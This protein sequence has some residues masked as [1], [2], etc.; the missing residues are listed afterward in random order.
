MLLA[1]SWTVY[2]QASLLSST[3]VQDARAIGTESAKKVVDDFL[4]ERLVVAAHRPVQGRSATADIV[5]AT[6]PARSLAAAVPRM[7]ASVVVGM[8]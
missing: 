7:P 6:V 4:D 5:T 2:R 3:L 8:F 1:P